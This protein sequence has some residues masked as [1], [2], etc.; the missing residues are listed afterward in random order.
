MVRQIRTARVDTNADNAYST[1]PGI[2]LETNGDAALLADPSLSGSGRAGIV[3]AGGV[4]P[5]DAPAHGTAAPAS[6]GGT[7]A[8]LMTASDPVYIGTYVN[9]IVLSDPATQNPATVA[10]TGYVTNQTMTY[11]GD[12]IYGAPGYSWTITNLGTVKSTAFNADCVHLTAGGVLTNGQSDSTTALIA[13]QGNG[14]DISGGSGTVTNFGTI[15]TGGYGVRLAAGGTVT[16]GQ[17]GLIQGDYP[18]AVALWGSGTV[19]NFGT[20]YG[21]YWDGVQLGAGGSVINFGTIYGPHA[22]VDFIGTLAG[23]V[24]NAGTIIGGSSGWALRFGGGDDLLVVDPG[25]VFLSK[26][27]G[28]FFVGK[29]DGGGGNNTLELAPG[30]GPGLLSGLGTN[31]VNFASVVFDANAAWTV[32][33]DNPEAF[34]GTISGFANGDILDLTGRAATGVW[35]SGGVLTVLN[36]DA[37]V[38]TLNLAG[39]NLAGSYTSA[40]FTLSSDGLGGTDIGIAATGPPAIAAP[41]SATSTPGAAVALF[42]QFIAAGFQAAADSSGLGTDITYQPQQTASLLA[43]PLHQ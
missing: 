32:T 39:F 11:N 25:A 7:D 10:A 30:A 27:D 40:D 43:A 42:G 28:A 8:P 12:A 29:V 20:I 6:V 37:T 15:E 17:G 1:P 4:A 24:M 19:T 41:S 16:N 14:V 22:A 36:G 35:Y 9:G 3:L 13:G 2:V 33:I 26:G 38:A 34:T 31:F 21:T 5:I 18:A 23:T